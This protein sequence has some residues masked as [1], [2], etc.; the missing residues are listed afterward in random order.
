MKLTDSFCWLYVPAF[1]LK[2]S[3]ANSHLNMCTHRV[4]V[5]VCV[6]VQC[7]FRVFR[8]IEVGATKYCD[9]DEERS[10]VVVEERVLVV[11][12]YSI[13][14]LQYSCCQDCGLV[15]YT[16]ESLQCTFL[17][18]MS[19]W[20]R[21]PLIAAHSDRWCHLLRISWLHERRFNAGRRAVERT[22]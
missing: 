11:V 2:A 17:Y 22:T 15:R 12:I 1:G 5:R 16:F 18:R 4:R 8:N 6:F 21:N 14:P 7:I 9:T 20:T 10:S 13:F 19:R 3:E